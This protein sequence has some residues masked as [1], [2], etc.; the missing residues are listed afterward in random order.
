MLRL[1]ASL[2]SNTHTKLLWQYT[3]T[4]H[5]FLMH[6][7]ERWGRQPHS[8]LVIIH[9]TTASAAAHHTNPNFHPLAPDP[10]DYTQRPP[11]PDNQRT[12]LR[13]RPPYPIDPSQGITRYPAH[14]GTRSLLTCN[15]EG[16]PRI[17]TEWRREDRYPLPSNSRQYDGNLI[18][19]DTDYDAAGVYEC[20]GISEDG[21]SF[22][23]QK[24]ELV[25]VAIPRI[26]FSP[27]MP[28]VVRTNDNVVILCNATGEE[29]L[30][31]TWH[32]DGGRYLPSSVRVS[33]RYLQFP[34]I[35]IEDAGRYFCTAS[36]SHGNAT[37]VAEVIVKRKSHQLT[38]IPL[39]TPL[40]FGSIFL[41]S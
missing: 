28:L 1:E 6:F 7:T 10:E 17:R 34:G 2:L 36:N 30:Q 33:G 27:T 40:L 22:P 20:I 24:V 35:T 39:H 21:S 25:V 37:K 8:R 5:S 13:P 31:V 41:Q 38:F 16:N 4:N 14:L 26:S 29:P 15:I 11:R 19:E 3:N 12:T 9:Q 23:L 18:I 32:L